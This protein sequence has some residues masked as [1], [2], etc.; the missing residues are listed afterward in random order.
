MGLHPGGQLPVHGI[1]QHGPEGRGQGLRVFDRDDRIGCRTVNLDRPSVV[2]QRGNVVPVVR[3]NQGNEQRGKM[4]LGHRCELLKRNDEHEFVG[5]RTE[6]GL[7]RSP[8]SRRVSQ[9]VCPAW[10]RLC[11]D[12]RRSHIPHRSTFAS[13]FLLALA[14][15]A[16]L[17]T[18]SRKS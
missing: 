10:G 2:R 12:R 17:K 11:P 7:M 6:R 13:L 14:A 8:E 3:Q 5:R 9:A 1:R 15:P 18:R 16:L 4:V